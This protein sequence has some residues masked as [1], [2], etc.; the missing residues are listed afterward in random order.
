MNTTIAGYQVQ[1][2]LHESRH[3]LVY[4]GR[5]EGGQPVVLKMLKHA[6]PSPRKV[7]AFRREYELIRSLHEANVI[8]AYTLASDQHRPVMVLEDF[9]G[10]SLARLLPTQQLS[11]PDLLLLTIQ[12]AD[13]VGQV[14][15]RHVIHKDINPSNIVWN[16]RS[17]QLK[18]IDFGIA[19]QLSRENPTF[20]SLGGLEGTLA[21]MSPEQTGRMNRGVDYRTDF[22][23]LGVT[24]YEVLTG[25]LPF[26]ATD[27]LALVHAHIAQQPTPP[28]EL[29]PDI[30]QPLS[31]IVMK[32]LA[33][34]AEDRYQSASGLIAD[35]QGCL[36]QWQKTGRVTAFPLG[37]QDAADRFQIPQ[38]LYGREQDIRTLLAAFTRVCQGGSELMLVSGLAGVGKTALVQELYKSLTQ[39]RG[40]FIAGKFDQFQRNI[41]YASLMQ[42]F[43]SLVRQLL[44][45]SE[46]QIIVWRNALIAA[47][48]TNLQIIIDV[49]PEVELIVGPQP[50]VPALPPVEGQNRFRLA[51][52]NFIHVFFGPG[53]PLVLFLDDLQWADMAS[54][55]LLHL[56]MATPENR[57]FF[58]IGAYRDNEVTDAHPV[59]LTLDDIHKSGSTVHHIILEPLRLPDVLHLVADTLA[60]TLEQARSLAE[61]VFTKTAGNPF[62]INEFLKS[63]YTAELLTFDGQTREWRWDVGRIRAQ[64]I[65]DNV[66]ALMAGKVQT[67]GEETQGILKI[68]ACLGD[69][70][71]LRTLATVC[72]K[73]FEKITT[74]LWPALEE[75]LVVP[76]SDTYKIMAFRTE[77][78]FDD[79]AAEYR[80]AHDRIQQAVYSLIPP[81]DRQVVHWRIGRLLLPKTSEEGRDYDLFAIV[82]HLNIGRNA[83]SDPSARDELVA[84]NL[85]AGQRAKAAAAYEPSF[86]YLHAGVE[87]LPGD[88]WEQQYDVTLMLHV[89]AAEAAYLSGNFPQMEALTSV[90]LQQ[91]D[92]LLDK[93]KAYEVMLHAYSAQN[94]LTEGAKIGLRVLELL[95]E[96]LPQE[97]S[98]TDILRA[99]E[100]VKR[101]LAGRRV[102]E[103]LHLPAMTNPHAVATMRILSSLLHLSYVAFPHL[104]PLVVARMINL[105]VL[106]GNL[107]LSAQAY[108]T[109]GIILCGA[110][111]DIETGY[112][113][114]AL[115]LNLVEQ[116]GA[117]ELTA[118]IAFMVHAYRHWKEHIRDTCL[119]LLQ[120]YQVGLET[121][122]FNFAAFDAFGYSFQSYWVGAELSGLEREMVKYSESMRQLKQHHTLHINEL[123]RQVTLNLLGQSQNPCQ[124]SGEGFDEDAALPLCFEANDKSTI[125][126]IYLHKLILG[127]L[128]H[129]YSRTLE[130]TAVAERYLESLLGTAAIPAFHFY[131]SLARLAAFLDA[132]EAEQTCILEKVAANQD[133]MKL[134]AQ[135]APMNYLHKFYLVEAERA[136]VLGH[137][138]DA[139]EY[140]DQAIDLAREHGYVNEEAIANE[141]AARFYLAKGQARLAQHYLQDA[142][143][144]YGCWGAVAK[145]RDLEA[146]YPQFLTQPGP[147]LS[148]S[149]GTM[150]TATTGQRFSSIFDFT[151]VLAASQAISG[152]IRLDKLVTRLMTLVIENAGAQ[153]GLLLLEKDGRL[154]IESE[155]S[156]ERSE[157]MAR[158]VLHVEAYQD[159]PVALVQYVARTKEPLTLADATQDGLFTN[160]PYVSRRRPKSI[161]CTPLLS[162]GRIIGLIYLENNLATGAFTPARL[163]VVKLLASQAAIS[164]ENAAL[165]RSLEEAKEKVED[166]S[167][168]LEFKVE[169]RTLELQKRNYELEIAN[170]HVRE[171]ARRKSQFLAGMSH[172]LRTP[173]NAILGF[174]RLVLRRA[175]DVLPERQRDNL[176]KVRESAD[177]LLRLINELLD[178][179]KI[180]AGRMEV[181][182]VLFD[183]GQ[184]LLTCCETVVPL[185]KPEVRLRHEVSDEVREAYTDE[186]G[187]RHIVLNLL[188]N[189]LK[190]T[191]TG[192][193]VMQVRMD[194]QAAADGS[195]VIAVADTG[196]GIPPDA[197]E[198]I[199]EEFQQVGGGIRERAGTGLG[200]PIAKRWAELLGGG[201]VV[202]SVLGRGSMFTVTIPAAYQKR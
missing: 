67:L 86:K 147:R 82:N 124:L 32:L 162:Q 6:H 2:Q 188:S 48:G 146:R 163:E 9:G 167:K 170:E 81:A 8:H 20:Q 61:L 49:I 98:Q 109:Y 59:Q 161:L 18:L 159:L 101:T 19:T 142:H 31:M 153:R 152:E 134:W 42:A 97:P 26:L 53:R 13:V 108:A 190:F 33:K 127:C 107:S 103:L 89:E 57:Y 156:L 51:F 189:A 178:L 16:P 151:S 75:G 113:F 122:D 150:F 90:V 193:V 102:E 28:H 39:Q 114:G 21:Y 71:D 63:L 202:E 184:F 40:Y 132:D 78:L 106:Q 66:V 174:T 22:Y 30:P 197:L 62:F 34:N 95:G 14:H 44:T 143:Y 123:H 128:F 171:A 94:N 149:G 198:T 157:N 112:R 154:V 138:C 129:Q 99:L 100:E 169:E 182:P 52:Q 93:V 192:E 116:L 135:H 74:D 164:I 141:L 12:I 10:E 76:L 196:V 7:A 85:K 84:L 105:S 50:P 45:E 79:G 96:W 133:K 23:S 104:F 41:P 60:C 15:Q 70:F 73:S 43:R 17:G 144:A 176:V 199:F 200:L 54:L 77:W 27:A 80:F 139:R 166:Y 201:I 120:G 172:E 56:L 140:Y 5:Q 187:L 136:R 115:A 68:A 185:V 38:K 117:R 131:N 1:E 160:D 148:Q 158:N 126:Y 179:S 58:I 92:T 64:H 88:A 121:G 29:A 145:V 55:Q 191:D 137:D 65:T 177:H 47:V 110:V 181:R 3:S 180:E 119:P 183:V 46:E 25:R 130:Y 118:S 195:L 168:T 125:C 4:R 173:M 186:D 72:E 111:A 91:A 87:L 24:L 83:I 35:V 36:R 165:Y 194:G 155:Y 11:L 175:G 37:Q 69:Q